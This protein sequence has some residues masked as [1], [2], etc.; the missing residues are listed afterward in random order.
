MVITVINQ[1]V[2]QFGTLEK[3]NCVGLRCLHFG[4][5]CNDFIKKIKFDWSVNAKWYGDEEV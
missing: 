3:K 5:S 2:P 1:G 4:F